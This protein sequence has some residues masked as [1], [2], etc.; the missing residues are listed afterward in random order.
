LKNFLI[1]FSIGKQSGS[2]EKQAGAGLDLEK[3]GKPE[4]VRFLCL[5]KCLH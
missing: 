3:V 4:E 2:K 5:G 1:E